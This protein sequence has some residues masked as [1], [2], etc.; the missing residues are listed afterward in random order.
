MSLSTEE[1]KELFARHNTIV[2]GG[3]F[4]YN[5]GKHGDVYLNKDSIFPHTKDLATLCR[6]IARRWQY[7]GCDIVIGPMTGG[8]LMSQWV[9]DFLSEFSDREILSTFADKEGDRFV[10]KRGHE[11]LIPNMNILVVEDNLTTGG[12]AKKVVTAVKAI[13][14]RVRG[15]AA[16]CNRGGVTA[17][18]LDV[19][20][21]GSLLDIT[22]D[23]HDPNSGEGCPLCKA[24]V[25]INTDLGHGK[26]FLVAQG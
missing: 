17:T 8:A 9:A 25:P 26:K 7:V 10:I 13:G 22:L 11:L 14:G 23:A 5:S 19:P 15:L 1:I 21:L 20:V 16:L 24:G 4:V 18:D 2:T 3:H 12:S 6:E